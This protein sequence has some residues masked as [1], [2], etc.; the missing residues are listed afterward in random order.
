MLFPGRLAVHS[1]PFAAL[2]GGALVCRCKQ[3]RLAVGARVGKVVTA[4]LGNAWL[5]RAGPP[6][7][8]FAQG[9][10]RSHSGD[11]WIV[12]AND[13]R[14]RPIPVVCRDSSATAEGRA[15]P[16]VEARGVNVLD[17][18]EADA[19]CRTAWEARWQW[20]QTKRQE[21]LLQKMRPTDAGGCE[22]REEYR[23]RL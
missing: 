15:R 18:A 2:R 23:E 19:C 16:E 5:H 20:Q 10:S 3:L 8:R 9:A 11:T 12:V 7:D 1:T 22:T 17:R 21:L 14:S 6:T 13:C 4:G